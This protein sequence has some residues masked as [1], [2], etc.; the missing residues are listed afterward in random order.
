LLGE[1]FHGRT[2]LTKPLHLQ[3]A[4]LKAA[5]AQ[6]TNSNAELEAQLAG[7][8][9]EANNLKIKVLKFSFDLTQSGFTQGALT[10]QVKDL[11]RLVSEQEE[12]AQIRVSLHFFP[13]TA[14]CMPHCWEVLDGVSS[15]L[16]VRRGGFW[17]LT[18]ASH[19]IGRSKEL[20]KLQVMVPAHGHAVVICCPRLVEAPANAVRACDLLMLLTIPASF[21]RI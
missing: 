8:Q 10:E 1:L 21:E 18:L 14:V 15:W 3:D 9:E 17:A 20:V 4:I 16:P 5:L 11:E 6:A 13:C 19:L 7:L 12:Q 2:P